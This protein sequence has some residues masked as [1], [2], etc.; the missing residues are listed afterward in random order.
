MLSGMN[1]NAAGEQ[2][3]E[4]IAN[5]DDSDKENEAGVP[6]ERESEEKKRKQVRKLKFTENQGEKTL[7][8][9]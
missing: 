3:I 7:D 6:E 4:I 2:E 8:K 1:R 5:Q 9:P